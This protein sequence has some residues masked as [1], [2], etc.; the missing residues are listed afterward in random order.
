M[1]QSQMI[2]YAVK[3]VLGG[4]SAFCSILLW[5]KTKDA[6]WMN[7]VVGI[8]AKY[9]GIVYEILS[10]LGIIVPESVVFLGIPFS[11]LIFTALPDIF[12]TIAFIL[13]L[14]RNK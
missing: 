8:V 10:V 1:T 11:T 7:L 6:V 12:F 9:V 5:S 13:M 2:L 14:K 4:I 3:L